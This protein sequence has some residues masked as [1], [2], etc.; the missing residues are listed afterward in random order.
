MSTT[1]FHR[2]FFERATWLVTTIATQ[3]TN[4][5]SSSIRQR[6]DTVVLDQRR[7]ATFNYV[8]LATTSPSCLMHQAR[9]MRVL[10][11]KRG[12]T[13]V[14]AD[15]TDSSGMGSLVHHPKAND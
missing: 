11:P 10:R 13:G 8:A 7:P 14:M 9:S 5:I 1:L 3:T 12:W 15:E 6:A 2:F 4:I